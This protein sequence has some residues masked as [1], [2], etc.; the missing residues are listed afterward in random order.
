LRVSAA[1]SLPPRARLS[2]VGLDDEQLILCSLCGAFC[3]N[4]IFMYHDASYCSSSC[5]RH[6]MQ[7]PVIV[8]DTSDDESIER[9]LSGNF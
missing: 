5:K 4:A 7:P 6:S 2:A 8:N 9:D 3:A 1:G